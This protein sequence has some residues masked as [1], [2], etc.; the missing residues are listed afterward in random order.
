MSNDVVMVAIPKELRDR[1]LEHHLESVGRTFGK[2]IRD[3]G[4]EYIAKLHAEKDGPC[5][6]CDSLRAAPETVSL[7][8]VETA[9]YAEWR[10][11]KHVRM[12]EPMARVSDLRRLVAPVQPSDFGIDALAILELML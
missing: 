7:E 1:Y 2:K 12:D 5:W 6:I 3:R 9:T 10:Y 8:G 11:D 4:I